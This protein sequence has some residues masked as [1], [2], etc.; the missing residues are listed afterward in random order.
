MSRLVVVLLGTLL[1]TATACGSKKDANEKNF[2]AAM[3]QYFEK[4][5]RACLWPYRAVQRF[6]VDVSGRTHAADEMQALAAVGLVEASEA[7]VE[8]RH[9]FSTPKRTYKVQRYLPTEKGKSYQD[10]RGRFCY[11]QRVLDKIVKWQG[12]LKWG[13]FQAAQVT[14][15]YKIAKLADW[16]NAPGMQ[17][18]FPLMARDLAGVGTKTA[19]HDMV[20]TSQGWE[21]HGLD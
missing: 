21:A 15:T 19:Q 1:L 13:E 12:P 6:P 16:A 2:A 18:Q 17:K 8:D 11:G 9:S 5:G 20:L 14:Y 3:T 4:K 10:E 7:E